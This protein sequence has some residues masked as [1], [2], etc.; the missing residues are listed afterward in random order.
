MKITLLGAGAWGTAL[1]I[2]FA[3]VR[4]KQQRPAVGHVDPRGKLIIDFVD[5]GSKAKRLR[6]S[7]YD[8]RFLAIEVG[9]F[10]H[11]NI[12]SSDFDVLKRNAKRHALAWPRKRWC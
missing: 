9:D 1:A 12:E 8:Q 4:A 5:Q 6:A 7:L 11:Y 2:A 3:F 10:T